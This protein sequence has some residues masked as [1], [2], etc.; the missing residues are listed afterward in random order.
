[1][2]YI[3]GGIM[4]SASY[5]DLFL[6]PEYVNQLVKKI[7]E[8]G[9]VSLPEFFEPEMFLKLQ[10]EV[11]TF[12]GRKKNEELEGTLSHKVAY[13]EELFK[14]FSLIYKERCQ[15]EKIKYVPISHNRQRAA[16][17]FKD[18]SNG[19][20]T[21]ATKYHFDGCHV[22]MVMPLYLPDELDETG[23]N[24]IIYKNLRKKYPKI[25]SAPIARILR[26]FK[27][28]RK[29]FGGTEIVY[30]ES[31]MQIFFGD[32]SL[33]GVEPITSGARTVMTIN[34]HW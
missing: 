24:L 5:K 9:Y 13:S 30:K 14:F 21:Q 6:N 19:Q 18:A 29:L 17:T 20:K 23:G 12:T 16:V 32:I 26:H 2:D 31:A 10:A 28:M 3:E 1:M 34:N 15:I 25:I 33:H 27:F 11:K 4:I 22:N 8:D 7:L